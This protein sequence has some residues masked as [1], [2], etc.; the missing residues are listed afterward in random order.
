MNKH[1]RRCGGELRRSHRSWFDFPRLALTLQSPFRCRSCG[2]R[3]WRWFIGW[4]P[5]MPALLTRNRH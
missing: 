2:A 1:C 5:A 3:S 4:R